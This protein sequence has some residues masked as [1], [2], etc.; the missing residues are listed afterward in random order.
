M[1]QPAP[2]TA[3]SAR[4]L[5]NG[6]A[7]RVAAVVA[8]VLACAAAIWVTLFTVEHGRPPLLSLGAVPAEAPAAER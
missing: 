6:A 1:T 8:V 5:G 7:G 3:P 4:R 2:Q